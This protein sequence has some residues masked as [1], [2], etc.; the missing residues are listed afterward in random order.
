MCTLP[1]AYP[2]CLISK[3]KVIVFPDYVEESWLGKW[4]FKFIYCLRFFYFKIEESPTKSKL[5]DDSISKVCIPKNNF[6][7]FV[8]RIK[9]FFCAMVWEV[10]VGSS[11][12]LIGT[13]KSIDK[14]IP[15]YTQKMT[16][17]LF[18]IRG[19]ACSLFLFISM[20]NCI[21]IYVC[22]GTHTEVLVETMD[23]LFWYSPGKH[24]SISR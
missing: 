24:D 21:S 11:I 1:S 13:P 22:R 12:Q 8:I 9:L 16:Y 7:K 20:Y 19:I 3:M 17:K 2:S 6:V 18:L 15:I 10:N 4:K 5:N 14:S 23:V